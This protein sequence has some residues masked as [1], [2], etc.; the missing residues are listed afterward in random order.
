MF[1]IGVAD[2]VREG[3]NVVNCGCGRGDLEVVN[4]ITGAAESGVLTWG[5][6]SRYHAF[7]RA[8]ARASRVS[9]LSS[10]L[11]GS[12]SLRWSKRVLLV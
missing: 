1:R 3:S 10:V 9:L 2:V 5:G 11:D 8:T 12:S 6:G 7:A 4:G